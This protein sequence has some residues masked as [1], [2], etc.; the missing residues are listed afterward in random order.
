M[1]HASE[2]ASIL[3]IKDLRVSY[4]R[5]N[6]LQG[7][8]LQIPRRS[9][10]AFVGS[11]GAG[12]TTTFSTVAGFIRQNS[13]QILLEGIPLREYRKKGGLIG[14]LP[15][16]VSFYED[17]NVLSQLVFMAKLSGLNAGAAR[18]EA[19]WAI[20][21]TGLKDKIRAYPQELSRGMKVR[22]GIAQAILGK[23]P[24]ILLDEPTAGL[25]PLRRAQ[26]YDL[27]RALKEK[28]TF[29]ISSHQLSELESLCDYVCMIEKGVLIRQGSMDDFLGRG[30]LVHYRIDGRPSDC[31]EIGESFG[32]YAF[33]FE[34]EKGLISVDTLETGVKTGELNRQ[35]LSWLFSREIGI[36]EISEKSSLNERYFEALEKGKGIDVQ[37]QHC[38]S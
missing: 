25:D 17:R 21:A 8:T 29:V 11:N 3:E 27:V 33:H 5:M 23:P 4:G 15:Q 6:A 12:K 34:D 2:N 38:Q 35:I 31:S 19:H 10:C 13:G 26:F 37:D 16:E 30:R 1:T 32:A 36:L 14:I 20:E 9:I 22:L 18:N 24:L 28:T 7:L